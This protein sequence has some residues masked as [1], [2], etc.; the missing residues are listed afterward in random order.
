MN[1][2]RLRLLGERPPKW[3]RMTTASQTSA[4]C[5]RLGC[6]STPSCPPQLVQLWRRLPRALVT[7]WVLWLCLPRALVTVW[8]LW[9]CLPRALPR[10]D[11]NASIAE[12]MA[13]AARLLHGRRGRSRQ[14][15]N[16]ERERVGRTH[17]GSNAT[18]C[19]TKLW[20]HRD[21]QNRPRLGLQH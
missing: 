8:V 1:V 7:V 10:R 19:S 15:P 16:L 5:F 12:L 13:C 20:R 18:L 17:S 6:C 2:C 11:P 4:S 3:T 21:S 14:W 9:R